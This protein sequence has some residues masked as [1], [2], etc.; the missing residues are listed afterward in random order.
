LRETAKETMEALNKRVTN[1]L[2]VQNP[3]T[4]PSSQGLLHTSSTPRHSRGAAYASGESA[5]HST[6][7]TWRVWHQAVMQQLVQHSSGC[8]TCPYICGTQCSACCASMP[9]QQLSASGAVFG[10]PPMVGS[11]FE[12]SV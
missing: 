11:L 10:A 6:S 1:K 12:C 8:Q 2:A 7:Q 5:M 3:S 4:L 9:G